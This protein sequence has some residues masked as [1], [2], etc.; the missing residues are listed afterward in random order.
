[1]RSKPTSSLGGFVWAPQIWMWECIPV[2][3]NV[4]IVWYE[5]WERPFD[6][7]EEWYPTITHTWANVQVS[8]AVT[9]R[10]YKAYISELDMLTYNQVIIQMLC[11]SCGSFFA[12]ASET[13]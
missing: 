8:C 11:H 6:G 3:H 7:D 9:M 10:R 1:M 12:R 2:G 13:F 4:T 5:P